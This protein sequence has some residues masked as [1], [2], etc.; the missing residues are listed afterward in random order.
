MLPD[1]I[2]ITLCRP[3]WIDVACRGIRYFRRKSTKI[4]LAEIDNTPR[5]QAAGE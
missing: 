3:C 2:Q 1:K 4:K 5:R